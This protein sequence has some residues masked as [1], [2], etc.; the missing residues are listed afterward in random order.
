MDINR[1]N[2]ESWFL[3]YIEGS[4][5]AGQISQVHHFVSENPDLQKE[6]SEWKQTLLKP[7]LTVVFHDKESLKR[8]RRIL[9]IGW[10]QGLGAV[11]AV[12]LLILMALPL[13]RQSASDMPVAPVA[14]AT[15]P[16]TAT[17][18][19]P[20]SD[21]VSGEGLS[22]PGQPQVAFQAKPQHNTAT[23]PTQLPLAQEI[24]PEK[25]QKQAP[26]SRGAQKPGATVHPGSPQPATNASLAQSPRLATG[27]S[28]T[29][30]TPDPVQTRSAQSLDGAATAD[31]LLAQAN[32]RS[33]SQEA[34]ASTALVPG[35]FR[36]KINDRLPMDI[37]SL[38][39]ATQT[40]TQNATRSLAGFMSGESEWLAVVPRIS[41]PEAQRNTE[42]MEEARVFRF[43][44][45]GFKVYHRKTPKTDS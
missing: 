43:S 38:L 7:D 34:S 18:S 17:Q 2:Y 20:L 22:S 42:S 16:D 10:V 23:Q 3:D 14:E 12:G 8:R 5:T 6:F 26:D 36:N 37:G 41:E 40:V 15:T 44:V 25:I 33:A 13:V 31:G 11:A 39:T 29:M 35:F 1:E 19:M 9:P 28:N 21:P 27:S 24:S 4:L 30:S 32:E 45:G